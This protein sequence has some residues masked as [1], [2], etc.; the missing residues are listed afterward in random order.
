M[1]FARIIDTTIDTIGRLPD[2]ARRLDND[3][4]VLGLRTAPAE[5][6]QVCGWY[7]IADTERPA[8]TPT[9][10]HDRSVELV[11]GTPTV[12]WTERA[13]T[14]QE[15]SNDQEAQYPSEFE[16][17][18]QAARLVVLP[19]LAADEIDDDD[20]P[21]F[22]G[23]FPSWTVGDTVKAGE[24]YRWDGTLVEVIQTHK[25]QAD[26]TP[27]VVPALFKVHRAVGSVA[28]W[29]QPTGAHD[30]YAL[31]ERVTFNGQTWESTN[32][33]NVWQPGVFGWVVPPA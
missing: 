29:V 5:L 4:W 20:A 9:T 26:W 7:E 2:S 12:V 13:K 16:S 19:K 1:T 14:D 30:A 31:G 3:R 24:V 8:D 21:L 32:A 17:L 11:A 22:A 6:Q 25:T 18:K 28:A 10:T 27:D 33:A 23:L 15:L